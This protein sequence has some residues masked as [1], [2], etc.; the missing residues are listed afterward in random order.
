MER[1]SV[2]PES[3]RG[4]GNVV[5]PKSISDF[6]LDGGYLTYNGSE[7]VDGKVTGSYGLSHLAD[8]VLTLTV[9]S[10]ISGDSF[11]VSGLLKTHGGLSVISG[12][13]VYCQVNNG[14][15]LSGTTNSSGVVEFTIPVT[16]ASVYG[17]RV[18][19]NGD[20]SHGAVFTSFSIVTAVAD[21][22]DLVSDKSVIGTG[23]VAELLAT[24]K[25]E[26]DKP[27]PYQTVYFFEEYTP[28]SINL[29]AVPQ[30]IQ[31]GNT[32][33]FKATLHDEDGS[34]I[35]GET[36]YFYEI[37][38][39]IIFYD[40]ALVDNSNNYAISE[41]LT[42]SYDSTNKYYVLG[43]PELDTANSY[44]EIFSFT[45]L[46]TNFRLSMDLY[47]KSNSPSQG[48]YNFFMGIMD[49]SFENGIIGGMEST[50]KALRTYTNGASSNID[51]SSGLL[52]KQTW[53][54]WIFEVHG[55]SV[56]YTVKDM[57]DNTVWSAS[58]TYSN[59]SR[60]DSVMVIRDCYCISEHYIKN[61]LI[62]EL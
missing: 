10:S 53:Y 12:A 35:E 50:A 14:D 27:V 17:G 52:T 62:E 31:S 34:L 25:T 1:I 26:D 22:I 46:P 33:D 49:S 4:L 58:G 28:Y 16:G 57:S 13:T 43:R 61:L 38:H 44:M 48:G 2:I 60:E 41:E 20:S 37:L 5:S 30:I 3:I 39:G 40:N 15:I 42:L 18:F 9:P 11:V 19:Y 56:V 55:N 47:I 29:S 7:L 54:H 51:T 21:S 24:V 6:M 8:C 59:W 23:D 32:S 45:E 36:I